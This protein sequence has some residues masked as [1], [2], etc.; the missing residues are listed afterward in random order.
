MRGN[1]RIAKRIA[2]R[3]RS[4][5]ACA[6]E[7]SGLSSGTIQTKVYPRVCG[8]TAR[9]ASTR[10]TLRGLSPRVRGNRQADRR[11]RRSG[12]SIPACAGEPCGTGA[13]PS[14]ISVYP[15]VCG[16]TAEA[17]KPLIGGDGLSPRVRGN[18]A[19]SMASIS[20]ERSI[21]ACAGEPKKRKSTISLVP[22]YPRVC[23]GTLK[24]CP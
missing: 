4:I 20:S 16:G 12:R 18:R 2:H 3:R 1:R 21:P 19:L 24:A 10:C 9:S 6:G 11:R 15:R 17:L 22:V 14:S 13:D 5:P 23:G 8:G 7:P